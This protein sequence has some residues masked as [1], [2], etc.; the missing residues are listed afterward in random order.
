MISVLAKI[1]N[2]MR[3]PIWFEQEDK[4]GRTHW[5]HLWEVLDVWVLLIFSIRR[6]LDHKEGDD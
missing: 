3:Y 4:F 1:V 6:R 2:S 5:M